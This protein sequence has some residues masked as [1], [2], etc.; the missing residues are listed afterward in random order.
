[1]THGSIQVSERRE[2]P[3]A[4]VRGHV[5]VADLPDFLGG[6]FGEVMAQLGTQ[7]LAAAGPPFARY[8]PRDGGFDVEAGFPSTGPVSAAGR[9]VSGVLP[10]GAV[11]TTVHR[12]DYGELG[13]TYSEIEKWLPA[14][15]YTRT[16]TPWESYLDG[17]DV[18]EPRTQV[19]FPCAP[20]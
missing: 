4:V 14:H 8:R 6:A 9:V 11:A 5:A 15:G 18:P 16:G 3:A 7:Q 10:G 2:E 1:M 17:P 20:A 12:G 13:Q 19:S